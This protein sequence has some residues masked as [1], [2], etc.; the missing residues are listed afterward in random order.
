MK[1][2]LIVAL[3]LLAVAA[4][5]VWQGTRPSGAPQ[6]MLPHWPVIHTNAVA[7]IDIQLSPDEHVRLQKQDG[8][9]MLMLKQPEP[10]SEKNVRHLIDDLAGMRVIRVVSRNRT[11]D[12]ELGVD[13]KGVSVQ[14]SNSSGKRLLDLV[15]G[16]QGSDL[17]STYVRLADALEVVAVDRAL[18]WQVRRDISSW[19][20]PAPV[21]GPM[22][23]K[24]KADH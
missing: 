14:L 21:P 8:K 15:V 2:R 17:L 19:K 3:L 24:G 7:R 6:A 4:W 12:A 23:K 22:E 10:A 5:A 20:A 16:K 9:W 11:H 1:S 13:D 18:V